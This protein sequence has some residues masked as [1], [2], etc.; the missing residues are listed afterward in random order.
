MSQVAILSALTERRYSE[1]DLSSQFLD[2]TLANCACK[3]RRDDQNDRPGA[4][5]HAR[6]RR[7]DQFKRSISPRTGE[8][9]D[10]PHSGSGRTFGCSRRILERRNSRGL[11]C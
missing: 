4:L 9:A 10:H 1:T 7:E 3:K 6:L 2:T 11:E 8:Y 5:R